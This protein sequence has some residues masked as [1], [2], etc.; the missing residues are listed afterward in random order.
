MVADAGRPPHSDELHI[1]HEHMADMVGVRR[2]S[3]TE[4]VDD[5]RATQDI[6]PGRG[7]I[8]LLDRSRVEAQARECY[9][10]I[11]HTVQTFAT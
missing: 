6:E 1:T 10:V 7:I 3:I 4:A 11:K 9:A 5:L 2:A 8:K